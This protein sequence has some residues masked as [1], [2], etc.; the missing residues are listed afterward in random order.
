[1]KLRKKGIQKI[2]TG[3]NRNFLFYTQLTSAEPGAIGYYDYIIIYGKTY[4]GDFSA[5]L[6]FSWQCGL[7]PGQPGQKVIAVSMALQR[8]TA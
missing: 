4:W 6:I 3:K 1:M 5:F 7:N 8:F 2:W